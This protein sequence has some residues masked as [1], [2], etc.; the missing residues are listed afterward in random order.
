MSAIKF[1]LNKFGSL[2]DWLPG[3]EVGGDMGAIMER[4]RREKRLDELEIRIKD[5]E[6]KIQ[7]R[8]S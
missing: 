4:V 3:G 6:R 2:I 1:L 7:N 5:L 8:G